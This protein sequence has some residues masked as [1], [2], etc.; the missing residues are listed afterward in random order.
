MFDKK[1]FFK[2]IISLLQTE[3]FGEWVN[4]PN[5]TGKLILDKLRK[6]NLDNQVVMEQP[7]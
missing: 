1:L 5:I 2:S 4:Y 7:I 3:Y 6:L